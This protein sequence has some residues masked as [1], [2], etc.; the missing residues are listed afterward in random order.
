MQK[1]IL[2]PTDFTVASLVQVKQAL[3]QHQNT[4]IKVILLYCCFITDSITELLFYSP[5]KIIRENSG[6]NFHEALSILTNKYADEISDI[7]IEIF[8]GYSVSSIETFVKKQ[9]IDHVFIS[10]SYVFKESENSFD[11]VPFI[12]KS[13]IAYTELSWETKSEYQ[14]KGDS[15]SNLF[16]D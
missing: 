10:K 14:I 11:I 8:H 7:Q 9:K 3:H 16:I 15:L 2:I 13:K 6:D 5:E 12:K 1:T 4:R